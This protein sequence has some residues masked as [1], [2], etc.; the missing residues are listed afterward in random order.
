MY[1]VCVMCVCVCVC[2]DVTSARFLR[3]WKT[4]KPPLLSPQCKTPKLPSRYSSPLR[5]TSLNCNPKS[6]TSSP[7]SQ[8]HK[9][10]PLQSRRMI[11]PP[12][13]PSRNGSSI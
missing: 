2:V 5:N 1:C 11:R 4:N 12:P 7:P 8:Q 10:R 13:F 6:Q 9:Q 3:S